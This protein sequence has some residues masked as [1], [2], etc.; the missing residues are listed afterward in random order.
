MVLK[1]STVTGTAG[2]VTKLLLLYLSPNQTQIGYLRVEQSRS[3]SPRTSTSQHCG[4]PEEQT[5]VCRLKIAGA[6]TA[7]EFE[8]SPKTARIIEYC[9]TIFVINVCVG[10]IEYWSLVVMFGNVDRC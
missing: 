6:G 10:V 9:M 5:D 1:S 3:A 4:V 7:S 2:A 8:T